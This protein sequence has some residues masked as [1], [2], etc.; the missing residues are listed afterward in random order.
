MGVQSN[1][2][3]QAV[4]S[5]GARWTGVGNMV[6]VSINPTME[7]LKADGLNP[8]KEPSYVTDE[9]GE[10]LGAR[11]GGAFKKHRLDI[12]LFHP[13]HKFYAKAAFWLENRVRYNKDGSKVEWINKFGNT[14][15]SLSEADVPEYSW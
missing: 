13:V 8:Q 10:A 9:I 12:N 3:G 15:W 4:V 6:V 5:T 2:S 14:A 11:E 1:N 7:E